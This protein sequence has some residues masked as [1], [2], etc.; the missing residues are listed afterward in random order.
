MKNG[1][2]ENFLNGDHLK[3]EEEE[4]EE[5]EILEICG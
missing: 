4:E 3:E 1:Y 2:L 5:K